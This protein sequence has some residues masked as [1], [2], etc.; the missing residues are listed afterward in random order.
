MLFNFKFS[1]IFEHA[2]TI[3]LFFRAKK[4]YITNSFQKKKNLFQII[5][6]SR[7]GYSLK[8]HLSKRYRVTDLPITSAL[9][10]AWHYFVHEL[11]TRTVSREIVRIAWIQLPAGVYYFTIDDDFIRPFQSLRPLSGLIYT[12][13]YFLFFYFFF[14][15]YYHC[16]SF[17]SF[18]ISPLFSQQINRIQFPF[19]EFPVVHHYFQQFYLNGGSGELILNCTSR[20]HWITM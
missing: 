12:I 15:L 1:P 16:I 19:I 20:M 14:L 11:H 17:F 6:V 8:Y 10:I 3:F 5:H 18:L 2:I 7:V 9:I 4:I 13:I